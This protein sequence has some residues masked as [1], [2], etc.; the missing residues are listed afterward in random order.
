MLCWVY[1]LSWQHDEFST[2]LSYC[3][4][5]AYTHVAVL[6]RVCV[7]GLVRDAANAATLKANAVELKLTETVTC[8]AT[9]L[10]YFG[11]VLDDADRASYIA[12]AA[13]ATLH[14]W[15]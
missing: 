13:T 10:L 4:I 3:A 6:A 12:T 11:S 5:C 14:G 15:W 7:P 1:V 2:A 9:G 8:G